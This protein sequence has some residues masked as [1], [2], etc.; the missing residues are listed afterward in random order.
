MVGCHRLG[1]D[2]DRHFAAQLGVFGAIHLTHAAFTELGCD[3]EVRN[4]GADQGGEI[5][6]Q[7]TGFEVR[8]GSGAGG[9]QIVLWL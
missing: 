2:L 7:T 8:P 3:T 1:Q 4:S 6:L 5:V 9:C